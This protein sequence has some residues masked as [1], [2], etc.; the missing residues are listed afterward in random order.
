M[1]K[2]ILPYGLSNGKVTFWEHLVVFK[3]ICPSRYTLSYRSPKKSVST[4][5]TSPRRFLTNSLFDILFLT[6]GLLRS[7]LRRIK[8]WH[9]INTLSAKGKKE[10]F[11]SE[12]VTLSIGCLD[13]CPHGSQERDVST[14]NFNRS[15][16][17]EH[18]S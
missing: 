12:W 3:A 17:T 8:E 16:I 10:D 11:F 5:C 15:Q 6:W 2:N 13:K 4:P 9:K 14:S 7:T 18:Y 1:C